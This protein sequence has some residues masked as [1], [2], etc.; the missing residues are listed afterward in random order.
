MKKKL[1]LIVAMIAV[2]VCL[3]A[4]SVSATQ[5]GDLH[6]TLTDSTSVE[7][8]D[9]TAQLSTDNKTITISEVVIP[10]TV[11]YE[12]KTYLVTSIVSNAFQN[13][14]NITSIEIPASI[15][16][17]NGNSFSGTSNIAKV[18]YTGTLEE[19]CKIKFNYAGSTPLNYS[20]DLYIN[21]ELLTS[22]VV[23][24]TVTS[25][26]GWNFYNCKSL[27]SVVIHAGVTSIGGDVFNACSNITSVEYKGTLEQ[28]Y[29]SISFVNGNSNPT[30][31]AKDLSI[32]G[33]IVTSVVVPESITKINNYAFAG[34]KSLASVQLHDGVKT[35]GAG[36][37]QN[38]TSLKSIQIPNAVTSFNSNLFNGCTALEAVNFPTKLTSIGDAVFS[39]CKVLPS[40]I[41][42]PEGVTS[43]NQYAFQNCSTIKY[44]QLPT[45]LAN[46]GAAA[47]NNCTSLQFV[48]FGD[49]Q[50]T[51]KMNSWGVFMG[52][53][54]LRALSLPAK[55][56]SLPDRCLN[57]CTSL[58]AV[59]MPNT[60]TSIGTNYSG[61][62]A[63]SKCEKLYF[64]QEPF[65]VSQEYVDG[66][67][68]QPTKP[69][70][71]Y[72]PTSLTGFGSKKGT[73]DIFMN[74]YAINKVI[75]FPEGFTNFHIAGVFRNCGKNEA[76]A[77]VF[78]GDMV[79]FKYD[80]EQSN[81][82][83]YFEN[84]ADIDLT[85]FTMVSRPT[86]NVGTNCKMVF[87]HSNTSYDLINVTG[88][89]T[90]ETA[91]LLDENDTSWHA[92][93]ILEVEDATCIKDEFTT[94]TCFCGVEIGT[95]KTG[96]A[97]GHTRNDG[98]QYV[99]VNYHN[100]YTV[101]GYYVY[102]CSR[103][104]ENYD[105]ATADAPALFIINGYS[106]TTGAIMQSFQVNKEAIADYNKYATTPIKY[107]ILAA[108]GALGTLNIGTSFVNGVISVDFTNRSY[109]IMEMKIYGITSATQDTQLYC[110]G[111]VMV[112]DEI[113]YM[114]KNMAD[115]AELPATVSYAGLGGTFAQAASLDAVVPTKE[116]VLA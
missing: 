86:K 18:N 112:D 61:Q 110:C 46:I 47:F 106:N 31:H 12:E 92:K 115:G 94:Y 66:D 33:E 91:V 23:P 79:N 100:K 24:E 1:L 90:V 102:A 5:I 69:D 95:E 104:Q 103:C 10:S 75:V 109:D 89:V 93:G 51:F 70:V 27:T 108:N 54:A 34:W 6:Y 2:L 59:Y 44:I 43:I 48:D 107:G 14:K 114:D 78:L 28:W 80:I 111:Y 55:L 22:L 101:N 16:V 64:V 84:K 37:F 52:C 38:C 9:G 42:I 68:A 71:Y 30:I 57:G 87:C 105:D 21:G 32:N 45:T 39:N 50:N 58:E 88:D 76:K 53:T 11:T 72:L 60:I 67:F 63:F 65:S 4:I 98:D 116:E 113:I 56:Q 35:L 62:G 17:F 13:N 25:I 97:L 29:S 3:F 99:A 73:E 40:I 15:T 26:S 83:Y 7:G 36:A 85:S 8:Y 20:K 19:W 41:I 77:V 96:D 81:I 49:N 82:T 74:C